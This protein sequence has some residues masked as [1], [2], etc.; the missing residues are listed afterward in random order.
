MSEVKQYSDAQIE[1]LMVLADDEGHAQW[2]ISERTGIE[3]SNINTIVKELIEDN[4]IFMGNPRK[5]TNPKSK[6]P[7]SKEFPL[8]IIKT[9]EAYRTIL[10]N[11][12]NR[13]EENIISI[14]MSIRQE[15]LAYT[16]IGLERY[17]LCFNKKGLL[18]QDD[19]KKLN[20]K[21]EYLR[22]FKGH[23]KSF[24]ERERDKYM[25]YFEKFI[26][27]TYT[28]RIIEAVGF[29]A[30]FRIDITGTLDIWYMEKIIEIALNKKLVDEKHIKEILKTM[31]EH[32]SYELP[33]IY[34]MK[35]P[36][37]FANDD[38]PNSAER[39]DASTRPED[40]E[41]P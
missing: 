16:Q 14:D 26:L 31:M 7:R 15:E 36:S 4:I 19:Y 33:Y 21:F 18:T 12:H 13:I 39:D 20:K 32:G 38:E 30:V 1:I 9:L 29:D 27:S 37:M 6:R 41:R 22:K 10:I 34:S 24:Y 2:E 17:K 25:D 8:Y 35:I 28:E 11:I 3:R 40:C 23:E 5:T